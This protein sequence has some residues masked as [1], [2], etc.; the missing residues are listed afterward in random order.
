MDAPE[1]TTFDI[2][3]N[4]RVV[5]AV[6]D[7]CAAPTD[8]IVSSDNR[9]LSAGGGVSE[10]IATKAGAALREARQAIIEERKSKGIGGYGRLAHGD[11]VETT[12]GLLPY[13][14]VIHLVTP[15][16]DA[17]AIEN[18]LAAVISNALSLADQ[19][20]WKSIAFPALAT[21]TYGADAEQVARIFAVAIER[22]WSSHP[23]TALEKIVLCLTI[24]T[25]PAFSRV[26]NAEPPRILIPTE[27]VSAAEAISEFA[28][29]GAPSID[30]DGNIQLPPGVVRPGPIQL[31]P[32]TEVLEYTI[33]GTLGR[34]GFGITYLARSRADGSRVA[35]KEY[36]PREFA[37]RKSDLNI[38]VTSTDGTKVYNWGLQRFVDEAELLLSFDHPNIIGVHRIWA[39]YNTA[40]LVMHYEDGQTLDRILLVQKCLDE[41][42]L[43]R[44]VLPLLEGLEVIHGANYIHR[45]IKP[46]N[47]YIRDDGTPVMID[48]GSARQ[49]FGE[50]TH[51]LTSL[52]SEGYSAIEQYYTDGKDQGPWT[53]I[54][55]LAATM[56]RCIAGRQPVVALKRLEPAHEGDTYND[57]IGNLRAECDGPYSEALFHAIEA[58]LTFRHEMRPRSIVEWG[59]RC[60]WLDPTF[61]TSAHPAGTTAD[62]PNVRAVSRVRL[63]AADGHRIDNDGRALRIAWQRSPDDTPP[64]A[65]DAIVLEEDTGLVL[66]ANLE[67]KDNVGAPIRIMTGLYEYEDKQVGA[68]IVQGKNPYRFL[69]IVHDFER[70]PPCRETWIIDALENSLEKCA[71]LQVTALGLHLLGS[72]FGPFSP[73]WFILQLESTLAESAPALLERIWLM[74]QPNDD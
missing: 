51:T 73:D 27:L 15:R 34:G 50:M 16:G 74:D 59:E 1:Q 46:G 11:V 47:I 17:A 71:E 55:G 3:P 28:T 5:I 63:A 52:V 31:P 14:A 43:R 65:V 26:F 66:N 44:L 30:K 4:R 68:V 32:G 6:M 13:K 23:S 70:E 45:D 56:Y 38:A 37:Y 67:V 9:G 29:D 61:D 8:V 25:Y 62:S 39:Q 35:I 19:R 2:A 18:S 69:A 7:I 72:R 53:D 22:F 54:Y 12:A 24:D 49:S 20:D 40:Y 58:G 57:P 48:F 60:A 41:D 42:Q 21:G 33:E 10:W 64:F 36:L